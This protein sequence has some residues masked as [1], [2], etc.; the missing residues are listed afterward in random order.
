MTD[1][2]TALG[3]VSLGI[4]VAQGLIKYYSAYRSYSKDVERTVTSVENFLRSLEQIEGLIKAEPTDK[5]GQNA[6]AFKEQLEKNVR[7]SRGAFETLRDE[8]KK[9]EPDPGKS[10]ARANIKKHGTRMLY[11]FRKESLVALQSAVADARSNLEIGISTSQLHK[12][13]LI[14]STVHETAEHI[15]YIKNSMLSISI[16]LSFSLVS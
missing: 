12:V 16:L 2:G 4:Q 6:V 9:V 5:K 15:A 10:G 13:G 8:W 7:T 3:A 14:E 11:P 1:P